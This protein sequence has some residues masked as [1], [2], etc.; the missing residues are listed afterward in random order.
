MLKEYN[1]I[2]VVYSGFDAFEVDYYV[3]GRAV[4]D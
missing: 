4:Q 1:T 2:L 3:D